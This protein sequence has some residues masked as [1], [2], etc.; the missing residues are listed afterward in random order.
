[1][2]RFQLGGRYDVITTNIDAQDGGNGVTQKD[3]Q[4]KTWTFGVH[5]LPLGH[6]KYKNVSLKLDYFIVQQDNRVDQ[7]RARG[8]LQ[9]V[10]RSPP[11]SPSK[12]QHRG[13]PR[14][15]AVSSLNAPGRS[16]GL[17]FQRFIA[18]ISRSPSSVSHG[19]TVVRTFVSFATS[20]A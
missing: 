8:Q 10:P 19:A 13:A 3:S 11:R 2:D 7:R 12:S 20:S 5:W 4:I 18:A 9:P 15:R 6:D 14:N 17:F 16:R 1:M